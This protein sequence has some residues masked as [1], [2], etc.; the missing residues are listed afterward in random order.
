MNAK[1]ISVVLGAF[2]AALAAWLYQTQ[3]HAHTERVEATH[4]AEVLSNEWVTAAGKL[5]DEQKVNSRLNSDLK[6]KAEELTVYSNRWTYVAAELQRTEADTK[7]AL[8]TARAE[9]DRRDKQISGLENDRDELGKKMNDLTGKLGALGG[10]I[11]ETERKLAASEGDRAFLQGQLKR[12]LTEKADLERKFADLAVLREQVKKLK[13]ELS[14]SRRLEMIRRGLYGIT[15]TKGATALKNG[16]RP[17]A[18]A[19]SK[20]TLE[21]EVRAPDSAIPDK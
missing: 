20:P 12:L 13:E 10:Q 18:P 2:S 8:D 9:I 4:R 19:V 14:I 21:G 15:E 1:W 5:S 11:Q 3:Q 16:I 6:A 17:P 7:T